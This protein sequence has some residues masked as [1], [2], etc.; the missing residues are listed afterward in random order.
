MSTGFGSPDPVALGQGLAVNDTIEVRFN[1]T[2]SA[3]DQVAFT[4][5]FDLVNYSAVPAPSAAAL[6]LLS[7][8][9]GGRHR[10]R[11]ENGY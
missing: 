11:T 1:F 9:F 10:R 4:G 2:L 6:I 7:P 8:L 5:T 3:G